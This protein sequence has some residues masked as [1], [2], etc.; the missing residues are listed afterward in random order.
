MVLVRELGPEDW[1]ILRDVRLAAL[2]DAPSAFG[3]THAREAAFG[4]ADW[5]RRLLSGGV[6]FLASLPGADGGSV[7]G[8]HEL[9]ARPCGLAGAFPKEPSMVELVSMWVDP[10]ARGHGVGDVLITS[11]KAWAVARGARSL[12]LWVTESNAAARSLYERHGFALTGERQPLPSDDR[13]N[14]IAMLRRLLFGVH[15]FESRISLRRP[16]PAQGV[17]G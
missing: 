3:S 10:A 7:N 8:A 15:G 14:E 4:E 2:S 17:G 5:R 9:A 12:H 13:L 6:T 11:V 1:E 16:R